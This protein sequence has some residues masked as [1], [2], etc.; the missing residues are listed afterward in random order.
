M[1]ISTKDL[2]NSSQDGQ[3]KREKVLALIEKH[4]PLFE[5]EGVEN[6]KFIPRLCYKHKGELIIGFY[7]RELYGGTDIY[8]EFCTRDFDP[9]DPER[10]LWKWIYNPEYE[11]E[12]ELSDPHPGTGDR[13]Y[14]IP[15]AELIDVAD[16][17]KEVVTE[18][19]NEEELFI[20]SPSSGDDVP[21][22][23]MTL[24]DYAAIQWQR[25]VS[26]KPWL[27]DLIRDKFK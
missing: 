16:Y 5:K 26:L 8:T 4:K 12:Y 27:N 15:I 23:A 13:R 3:S 6:P 25:P 19:E 10:R 2:T 7:P 21:Y 17:H 20:E 1:S 22:S 9:E 24:R 14:I 18:I 11:K